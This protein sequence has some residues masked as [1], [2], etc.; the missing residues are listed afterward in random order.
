MV[1]W[2]LEGS[3]LV[4]RGFP[5]PEGEA[6]GD[7]ASRSI[8]GGKGEKT[9]VGRACRSAPWTHRREPSRGRKR[10]SKARPGIPRPSQARGRGHPIYVIRIIHLN[11]EEPCM[12]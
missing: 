8:A 12:T 1:A 3:R 5:S 6:D 11:G 2:L 7:E 10:G 4:D 9:G